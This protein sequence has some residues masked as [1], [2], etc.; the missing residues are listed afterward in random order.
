[1]IHATVSAGRRESPAGSDVLEA[2]RPRLS[3]SSTL[4]ASTMTG[5]AIIAAQALEIEAAE[6]VP[7]R[8]DHERVGAGG[9]VVRVGRE[10]DRPRRD[11]S[12]AAA[13]PAP[14]PDRRRAP[15][16]RPGQLAADVERRRLAN[17]V[18][19]RLEREAEHRDVLPAHAAERASDLL[20]EQLALPRVD[21]D[22]R[23]DN[24]C[25]AA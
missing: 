3:G 7:F 9:G 17:V 20:D 2:E 6:L 19:V 23:F 8:H 14:R 10:G 13:A 22:G 12:S 1:M 11:R 15:W 4:R 24:R 16:P 21:V 18:G 5:L 25:G